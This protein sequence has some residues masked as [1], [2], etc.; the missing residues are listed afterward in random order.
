MKELDSIESM[1][2]LHTPRYVATQKDRA[3][4]YTGIL[5]AGSEKKSDYDF[6]ELSLTSFEIELGTA[7]GKLFRCSVMSILDAGE[8]LCTIC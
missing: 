5:R 4:S 3:S 2:L 1:A 6:G 7:C 8:S